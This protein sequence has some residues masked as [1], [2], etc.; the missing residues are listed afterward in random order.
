MSGSVVQH[1]RT[2]PR[3]VHWMQTIVISRNTNGSFVCTRAISISKT[4]TTEVLYAS[5][6]KLWRM[7]F[8]LLFGVSKLMLAF[9]GN[10]VASLKVLV[11]NVPIKPR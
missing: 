7:A 1:E 11:Q 6:W 2:L 10:T 8:R 4:Q 9:I 3:S 5:V